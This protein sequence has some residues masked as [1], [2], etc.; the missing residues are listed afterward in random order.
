[1]SDITKATIYGPDMLEGR[2]D[3]DVI[4]PDEA[5]TLYGLFNQRVQRSPNQIAYSQYIGGHWQQFSWQQMSVLID[6]WQAAFINSGL[7]KGDRVAI[8]LPNSIYWVCFDQAAHALGLVVVPLYMDDRAENMAY[9]LDYTQSQLLFIDSASHWH[10]LEQ[11]KSIKLENLTHIIS[12]DESAEGLDERLDDRL[13]DRLVSMDNWLPETAPHSDPVQQDADA[14]ASIIFTSGTT[15]RP[16]GVMLSHANILANAYSCVRY[17]PFVPEDIFVSFL[18]LSHT[19]ERTVGYYMT[20]M[21]GAKVVYARSISELGEDLINHQPTVIVTV[22]RIFERVYQKIRTQLDEGSSFKKKLFE[23]AV[24]TGWQRFEHLQGRGPWKLSFLLFPILDKLVGQ[25]I[26]GKLGG[27]LRIAIAGGAPLPAVIGKTFL[28]LG[29]NVTQGYG[30]TET[31]PVLSSN[32]NEKNKPA[33]IGLPLLDVELKLG[34][35]NEILAKGP[36]VMMGYWQNEEATKD[37]FTEDGWLKT[38][39]CGKIDDEGYIHIIGRIKEI[40]VLANGEKVPPADMESAISEDPLFE[41]TM[42]IG[43]GKPYLSVLVV[44]NKEVWRKHA[45]QLGVAQD[46]ESVFTTPEIEK[47]LVGRIAEQ[48]EHFPGYAK[49]YK[50]AAMLSP[51]TVENGLLTPTL[52]LKRPILKDTFSKEIAELYKGH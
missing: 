46:D 22:P 28:A 42:V 14:L 41:Q 29:V 7:K 30:M 32:L 2:T 31:S 26:R 10:E 23:L 8:L 34:E 1:M 11:D 51:W 25:K 15:G 50:T 27:A 43:E 18:P 52:K 6:R 16:K 37:T 24:E 3:I 19:F 13:D 44:L 38:G 4:K 17:G 36:N 33:S 47:F 9:I 5:G 12:L 45:Q 39:D 40:L 49:I 20:I 21:A 48:I 35:N